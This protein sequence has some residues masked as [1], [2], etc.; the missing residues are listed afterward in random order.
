MRNLRLGI[1]VGS[2]TAKAVFLD[3]DRRVVFSS[4]RRHDARTV[5]TLRETLRQAMRKIGDVP[6]DVLPIPQL[7]EFRA[8]ACDLAAQVIAH[9]RTGQ[10]GQ[11]VLARLVLRG[12][13]HQ[14]LDAPDPPVRQRI[15]RKQHSM[16]RKLSL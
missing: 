5:D 4:Y 15:A 12:P 9:R 1:D 7:I 16:S 13:A 8:Q 10:H 6:V 2:T 11:P 3:S 14:R